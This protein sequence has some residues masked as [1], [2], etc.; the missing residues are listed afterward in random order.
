[1]KNAK[2]GR[3]KVGVG[4]AVISDGKVLLGKRKG[5]H[6]GAAGPL[7]AGILNLGRRSKNALKESFGKRLGLWPRHSFSALGQMT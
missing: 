4:V 2:A 3:R 1:M 6:G 7:R 5:S